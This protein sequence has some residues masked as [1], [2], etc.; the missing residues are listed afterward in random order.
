LASGVMS[1]IGTKPTCPDVRRMAVIEGRA[2]VTAYGQNDVNDRCCRKS[3][4][5]LFD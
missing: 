2:E 4:K 3:P 1:H 5:L